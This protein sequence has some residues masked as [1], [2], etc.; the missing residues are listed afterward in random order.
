MSID[1]KERLEADYTAEL[2]LLGDANKKLEEEVTELRK[3]LES[4]DL[5]VNN[6]IRM[7][8]SKSVGANGVVKIYINTIKEE[9]QKMLKGKGNSNE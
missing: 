5:V 8:D 7:L 9:I 4:R 1:E 2:A 3:S 6:I